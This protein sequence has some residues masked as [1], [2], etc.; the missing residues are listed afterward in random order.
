MHKDLIYKNYLLDLYQQLQLVN[1]VRFLGFKDDI[2]TY[3]NELDIL[4]LP[5]ENE[6]FGR[7]LIEAMSLGVPVIAADS[8]AVTE[9]IVH[10]ETGI[11]FK[12]DDHKALA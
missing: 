7:I 10:N 6:P 12:T 5:S 1:S 4:V 8:G 3:I 9:I 11:T 2:E